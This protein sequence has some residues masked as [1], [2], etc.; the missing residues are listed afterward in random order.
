MKVSAACKVN[1]IVLLQLNE[2]LERSQVEQRGDSVFS[3]FPLSF[4]ILSWVF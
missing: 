3:V 4:E 2:D 1:L